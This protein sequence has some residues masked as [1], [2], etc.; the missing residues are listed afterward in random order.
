MGRRGIVAGPGKEQVARWAGLMTR[1]QSVM[2][3][4][5]LILVAEEYNYDEGFQRLVSGSLGVFGFL[6]SGTLA[7][8]YGG[9]LVVMYLGPRQPARVGRK[10]ERRELLVVV[11]GTRRR[12]S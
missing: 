7:A 3:L 1:V 12:E 4:L 6:L 8:I 10:V 11:E 9:V 2:V 5:L